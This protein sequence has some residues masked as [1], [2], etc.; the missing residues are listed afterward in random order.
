MYEVHGWAEVHRLF[1]RYGWTKTRIAGKLEMSRNRG[2]GSSTCRSRR[3]M[4]GLGRARSWTGVR[5]R[6]PGCSTTMRG[7]GDDDHRAFFVGM[8]TTVGSPS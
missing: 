5:V 1:H 8:A 4:S 3:G 2:L 7:A 6:S